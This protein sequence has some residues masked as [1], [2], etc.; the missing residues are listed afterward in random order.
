MKISGTVITRLPAVCGLNF[1]SKPVTGV[2][3][4]EMSTVM[5]KDKVGKANNAHREVLVRKS[6]VKNLHDIPRCRSGSK[7]CI[8]RK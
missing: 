4:K 5:K 3:N 7:K 8:F 6:E 1:I 2:R